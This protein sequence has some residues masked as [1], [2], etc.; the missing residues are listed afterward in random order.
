[1]D[2]VIL[3]H[4]D[5][6]REN[7]LYFIEKELLAIPSNQQLEAIDAVQKAIN[8]EG[9]PY[10]SIRS[11]HGCFG[12]NTEIMLSDGS[13]KAVQDIKVGDKLMGDDGISIR[14]VLELYRGK[15]NMYKFTYNDGSHHI[16]NESHILCL[17]R[18][19][20][21]GKHRSGD[22]L[23][24]TVKEYLNWTNE[25]KRVHVSYRN[26]IEL[27]ENK[28]PIDPYVLGTWIGDGSSSQ[29][30]IWL[31]NKKQIIKDE[32][33]KRGYI[34]DYK[35]DEGSC[36]KYKINIFKEL[37]QLN[38]IN[39]KHIPLEYKYSS[40]EQRL[41]LIAGLLD[42][43]G[44]L[45]KRQ[46]EFSTKHKH[47]A[48][49]FKYLCRSVG[50]NANVSE[51][52][53]KDVT[54]YRVNVGRN[55]EIIPCIR[56]N[57]DKTI[58]KQ[59]SSLRYGIKSVE[60]LGLGDYYGFELDGNHRFLGG[61]FTVLH[62]TGKTSFLAWLILWVGLTKDDA[63]IPTTAPVSDQLK[64]LLI[65]EVNKWKN[66]MSDEF[67]KLVEV[68]STDVRFL[69]KNHCFARTAR[70]EN[71]EALAGVHASFVC[72]IADEASGIDQSVFD[73]IEGALTGSNFLFIMTS[74]PTK[75]TGTFFDSHNKKRASYQTL[76]FDSEKSS[77]V[78][79][80][81]VAD[82]E[83]KYGRD[84][85]VFRVRVNG[86]F[87]NT[88]ATGLFSLRDLEEAVIRKADASGSVV[89]GVDVA[90]YGND[91]S[92]IALK[93]GMQLTLLDTMEQ[94]S[95]TE[96]ANRVAY[97]SNQ[98]GPQG[99][100]VDTIGVGAG[101]FD[102]LKPIAG[103][104]LIDGNVGF[105]AEDTNTYLNKRAEAYFKLNN[106]IKRGASIP[107]DDELIEELLSIEYQ[108]TESGKIKIKSKDQI[109]EDL[110]RSPDK[111]DAFMLLYFK[112]VKPAGMTGHGPI[113]PKL[114]SIW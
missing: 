37:K 104:R 30:Y 60:P 69:N 43:D 79:K 98:V 88:N 71:T 80:Q 73:V 39:N 90:R 56:H 68:Q 32:I 26:S 4:V 76:H 5:N 17:V 47:I 66:K 83:K 49:D 95:T 74:N 36:I 109:K 52:T 38:L 99:I 112:D 8:K 45:D 77:N 110:G 13:I 3:D 7:F 59:R 35:V 102:Q 50:C 75:T 41:Q 93:R 97:H 23:T 16:F 31:G 64:N 57:I 92:I 101:V 25:K 107:N 96:V 55:T 105:A 22:I 18:T 51:K 81:W 42:T 11:G 2:K 58:S 65:P 34:I 84:S 6:C 33:C 72:Y 70:K 15:E 113:K 67:Q 46:Y 14:N 48:E 108:F 100:I 103:A 24:P 114:G 19:Q 86:D 10:I 27:T 78:N 29:S 20:T 89:M 61:D 54:Y 63:K 53:V 94:C 87:P 44:S 111:A 40:K 28:L 21:K 91:S 1:M 12:I 85:D 82:M 106:A 62:N 9:L